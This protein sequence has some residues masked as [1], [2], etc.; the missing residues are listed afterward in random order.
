MSYKAGNQNYHYTAII[1]NKIV[2]V[3]PYVRAYL[4]R[5]G[6]KGDRSPVVDKQWQKRQHYGKGSTVM[7]PESK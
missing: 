4:K 2:F 3:S 6:K 5:R 1:W 7:E